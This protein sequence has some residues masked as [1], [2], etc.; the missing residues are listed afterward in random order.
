MLTINKGLFD[1]DSEFLFPIAK[2]LIKEQNIKG[3]IAI[4]FG[5]EDESRKLNSNYR[6]VDNPTDVL[7]F[8]FNE[9]LQ[10]SLYLGDI[11][12]CYPIAFKQAEDA[13]IPVMQEII[14]LMVHGILHL[15]GHDH[16]T[17]NGEMLEIQGTFIK[18]LDL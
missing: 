9:E 14:T 2:K 4:K 5:N 12:I 16:E 6:K 11:L 7:S 15:A 8:P 3:D 18:S 17:D 13:F 10:G 1:V